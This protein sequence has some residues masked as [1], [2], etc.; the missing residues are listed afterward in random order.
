MDALGVYFNPFFLVQ[1]FNL[2]ASMTLACNP[3][4]KGTDGNLQ[5]ALCC[6]Q[7]DSIP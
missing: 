7:M 1:S 6:N 5:S 2:V 3:H 4:K